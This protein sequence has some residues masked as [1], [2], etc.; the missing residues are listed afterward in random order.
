MVLDLRIGY[1]ESPVVRPRRREA[2]LPTVESLR[3][4]IRERVDLVRRTPLRPYQQMAR[5]VTG[6]EVTDFTA[7]ETL[8][9]AVGV[10]DASPVSADTGST[11]RDAAPAPAQGVLRARA[12]D[13]TSATDEIAAAA[14]GALHVRSLHQDSGFFDA[15]SPSLGEVD[16]GDVLALD[17]SGMGRRA[18]SAGDL[19]VRRSSRS[20]QARESFGCS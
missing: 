4:R 20:Q 8:R 16:A 19:T 15:V 11:D 3:A 2:P 14:E 13:S 1:E 6:Q 10:G 12:D 18:D 17:E 5:E 9:Q 7:G